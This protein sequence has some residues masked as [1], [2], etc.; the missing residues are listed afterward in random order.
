MILPDYSISGGRSSQAPRPS[1]P[2]VS[3]GN[4]ARRQTEGLRKMDSGLKT[5]GMTIRRAFC[6]ANKFTVNIGD[7]IREIIV[8]NVTIGNSVG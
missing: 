6:R 4:P 5:A 8:L 7:C 2:Q 3:S 1:F